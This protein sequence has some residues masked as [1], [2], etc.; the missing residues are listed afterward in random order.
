MWKQLFAAILVWFPNFQWTENLAYFIISSVLDSAKPL[1]PDFKLM[2]WF[3]GLLSG[4]CLYCDGSAFAHSLQTDFFWTL[5]Y[6]H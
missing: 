2:M 3:C 6:V 4:I 5:P 1:N